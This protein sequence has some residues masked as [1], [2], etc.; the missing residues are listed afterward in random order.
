MTRFKIDWGDEV[1]PFA[2]EAGCSVNDLTNA[3]VVANDGNARDDSMD[4]VASMKSDLHSHS[5]LSFPTT[6][7]N[8]ANGHGSAVEF[9]PVHNICEPMQI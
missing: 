7:V 8:E 4:V 6:S 3:S 1:D 5:S 2:A 9:N